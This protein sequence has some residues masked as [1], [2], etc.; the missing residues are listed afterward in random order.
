VDMRKNSGE[1]LQSCPIESE[2]AI[3]AP[4]R[5]SLPSEGA[6]MIERLLLADWGKKWA[7]PLSVDE[8]LEIGKGVFEQLFHEPPIGPIPDYFRPHLQV[9][10]CVAEYERNL[11]EMDRWKAREL[12]L[13]LKGK[14][15]KQYIA[16][17]K[18]YVLRSE[19]GK[20]STTDKYWFELIEDPN[21]EGI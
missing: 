2:S 16:A 13:W 3:E 6:E 12:D 15:G 5:R 14:T 7:Q 4:F 1:N 18:V 21:S 8:L 10:G 19:K 20:T 17:R 11:E 9:H